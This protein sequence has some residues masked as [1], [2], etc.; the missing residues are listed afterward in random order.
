M[1]LRWFTAAV[2]LALLMCYA[3]IFPVMDLAY[4]VPCD[5]V[6]GWPAAGDGPCWVEAPD[7]EVPVDAVPPYDAT[8]DKYEVSPAEHQRLRFLVMVTKVESGAMLAMLQV[9]WWD[10]EE[11]CL[12]KPVSREEW[13]A[14][15]AWQ[16]LETDWST[17]ED[18]PPIHVILTLSE[19]KGTM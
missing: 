6:P 16:V 2:L 5:E 14:W 8:F 3:P 15:A 10:R 18:P 19:W 4:D 17:L 12:R 1:D 9:V 13:A 11:Y 7:W